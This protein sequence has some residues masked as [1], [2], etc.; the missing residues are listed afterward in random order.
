MATDSASE[1]ELKTRARYRE[2]LIDTQHKLT[3]S[4]DKLLVTLSGGALALS[5][6]FLK[7]IVG[8]SGIRHSNLLLYS[9]VLFIL[10]LVAILIEIMAGISAHKV[11]ILQYD[12]ESTTNEDEKLGGRASTITRYAHFAAAASLALGLFFIAAFAYFNLENN[13]DRRVSNTAQT[14]NTTQTTQTTNTTQTTQTTNTAQTTNAAK[15]GY[16]STE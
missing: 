1:E 13:D 15:T 8:E 6:T 3:E 12:N 7:D 14:T 16:G 9:W 11:A 10:S 2:G 4:Y 5:I